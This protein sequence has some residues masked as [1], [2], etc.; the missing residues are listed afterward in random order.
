VAPVATAL[1]A[2]V[3][4]GGMRIVVLPFEDLGQARDPFFAPGLT[5]EVTK[6][7]GSLPSLQVIYR[8]FST[9]Q[10]G[11]KLPHEIGIEL[12]VNYVLLGTV[13]WALQPGGRARVRIRPQL[14][15]VDGVQVWA[16]SFDSEIEDVFKV[17]AEIS[18]RVIASLGI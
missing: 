14:I 15:R 5:Q 16:D 11:A 10:K 2:D 12:G 4:A 8:A 1:K 7:L 17:Q 6:D 18:R 9:Q 3:A 13:Q